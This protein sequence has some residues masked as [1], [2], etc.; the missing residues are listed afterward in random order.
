MPMPSRGGFSR[1]HRDQPTTK[2]RVSVCLL[3]LSALG[4]SVFFAKVRDDPY[5]LERSLVGLRT[6]YKEQNPPGGSIPSSVLDAA[7][8]DACERLL[9]E[10]S[11]SVPGE[12]E[13]KV[14]TYF[15]TQLLRGAQAVGTI[16]TQPSTVR[17]AQAKA[18]VT[19]A[20][21]AYCPGAGPHRPTRSGWS[22]LFDPRTWS[23]H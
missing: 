23:G 3:L 6:A 2:Q 22:V 9:A 18:I 14:A 10:P 15:T 17:L 16:S 1:G 19:A 7:A 21:E 20:E 4:G 12:R 13:T 8:D 5:V 11:S